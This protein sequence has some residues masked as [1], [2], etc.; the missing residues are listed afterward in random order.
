MGEIIMIL[1]TQ[2]SLLALCNL[3]L[4]VAGL[5]SI[6]GHKKQ[7]RRWWF[8]IVL[9][10]YLG[11][12]LSIFFES[13]IYGNWAYIFHI[14]QFP[15]VQCLAF[16]TCEY[17]FALTESAGIRRPR[18]FRALMGLFSVIYLV[19]LWR[20]D[21]IGGDVLGA[22]YSALLI[23]P[24][25]TIL[26]NAGYLAWAVAK[27]AGEPIIQ[28]DLACRKLSKSSPANQSVL[29]MFITLALCVIGS[30]VLLIG[31]EMSFQEEYLLASFYIVNTAILVSLMLNYMNFVE[32]RLDIG[33]KISGVLQVFLLSSAA[34]LFLY[35]IDDENNLLAHHE[36]MLVR[37]G[38]IFTAHDDN[39]YEVRFGPT[40]W[41]HSDAV[42]L[43]ANGKD[44]IIISLPFSFLF[45]GKKYDQFLLH[46]SGFVLPYLADEGS[47]TNYQVPPQ[48]CFG[49]FPV[50]APLCGGSLEYDIFMYTNAYKTVISWK[51]K[52]EKGTPSSDG[53]SQLTIKPDGTITFNYLAFPNQGRMLWLNVLGISS[54]LENL[55]TPVP[56]EALPRAFPDRAIWFDLTLEQRKGFHDAFWPLIALLVLFSVLLMT[57]LPPYLR[58]TLTYPFN[59]IKEGLTQVDMGNLGTHLPDSAKDEFGDLARG[60][61]KM[62]HSLDEARQQRDEQTELLESE[63]SDHTL[64]LAK[65]GHQAILSKDAAF[66]QKI[67]QAIENNMGDFD[68]QVADLAIELGVSPRQLHRRIVTVTTQTPAALVRTLRLSKAKELLEAQAVN[69]SEA[70]YKTGFRDVSYF[71]KLFAKQFGQAPSEFINRNV[72][73]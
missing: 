69:V 25:G 3:L 4:G 46:P 21:N 52:P 10:S 36:Q 9:W 30:I 45:Y 57:V 42:R 29:G 6:V 61:N 35:L 12:N 37:Q 20:A 63:L 2:L 8:K 16:S 11:F 22:H 48:G 64:E 24:I 1:T 53:H 40:S 54:G 70:A 47:P 72:S 34:L 60:F 23:L 44:P 7:H 50:I 27:A 62:I 68:F 43:E 51:D 15:L 5:V 65:H 67:Q 73:A 31:R 14:L 58:K 41:D 13:S 55:K 17:S 56:F 18:F 28:L 39:L 33:T 49:N 19:G 26:F 32:E 66:E 59:Q 71:S 38:L